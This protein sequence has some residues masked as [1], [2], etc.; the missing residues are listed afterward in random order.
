MHHFRAY[1]RTLEPKLVKVVAIASLSGLCFGYSIGI[2]AIITSMA[3]F[4]AFFGRAPFGETPKDV[5]LLLLLL[6][7]GGATAGSLCGGLLADRFGRKSVMQWTA[8]LL[9][10]SNVIGAA[11]YVFEMLCASRVL[12]GIMVGALSTVTPLYLAEISPDHSRGKLT[13]AWQLSITTGIVIAS[14]IEVFAEVSGMRCGFSDHP[15]PSEAARPSTV[16]LSGM[17]AYNIAGND[18][19]YQG[20]D[21]S[22]GDVGGGGYGDDDDDDDDGDDDDGGGGGGGDG[23]DDGTDDDVD[24]DDR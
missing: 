1:E 3:S 8:L 9:S 6:F 20:S 2:S 5:L 17:I 16:I 15:V 7:L 21:S 18:Y 12:C 11:A 13:T 23:D 24:G 4:K 10:V 22:A 14:V 19:S